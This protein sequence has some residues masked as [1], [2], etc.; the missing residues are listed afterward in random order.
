MFGKI[1]GFVWGVA[2]W[3]LLAVG[4]LV[5]AL[6]WWLSSGGKPET[7]ALPAVWVSAAAVNCECSAG[8]VCTG[9]RGGRYCIKPDGG[10][11]YQP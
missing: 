6:V 4:A 5:V 3:A 10:K 9:P 7:P 8:V 2:K 11:K 1:A